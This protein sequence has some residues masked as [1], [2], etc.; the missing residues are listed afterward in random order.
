MKKVLNRF[1]A[2][3]LISIFT[4]ISIVTFFS[5]DIGLGEAVDVSAPTIQI[6]YPPS[7]AI[8]K[9]SF[10]LSGEC[11]DDVLVT[12]VYIKVENTATKKEVYNGTASITGNTWEI[13]LNNKDDVVYESTNGWQYPDGTYEVTAWAIDNS[14]KSSGKS[15]RSFDIDNTAPFFIISKPGVTVASGAEPAAYGSTFTVTGTIADLHEIS[16]MSLDVYDKNGNLLTDSASANNDQNFYETSIATAG[17]TSVEFA[18]TTRSAGLSGDVSPS[19]SIA[20]QR[21]VRLYGTVENS[22][23]TSEYK[24]TIKI[25]DSAKEY[26]NPQDNGTGEGN[27]TSYVYLNDDVYSAYLSSSKGLGLSASS[28]MSISNGTQIDNRLSSKDL[29]K[30]AIDTSDFTSKDN[31]LAFTLNPAA[32]PTYTLSGLEIYG[33][34]GIFGE[35]QLASTSNVTATVSAGL[36]NT[37]VLPN[38]VHVWVKDMTSSAPDGTIP[39]PF[40]ATEAK[41]FINKLNQIVAEKRAKMDSQSA[42]YDSNYTNTDFKKDV[43][44]ALKSQNSDDVWCVKDNTSST[45]SS[46]SLLTV[47]FEM[48]EEA[49]NFLKVNH[50][51][52]IALTGYDLDGLE[53]GQAKYYGFKATG[54][55]KLPSIFVETPANLSLVKTSAKKTANNYGLTFKGSAKNGD[56]QIDYI[57]AT[58]TVKDESDG[59]KEV[60]SISR[61][62]SIGTDIKESG[63]NGE[64]TWEFSPVDCP[65]YSSVKCEEGK[66][67]LYS[68]DFLV[69]SVDNSS[70]TVNCTVH[71]DSIKPKVTITSITPVISDYD[72]VKKSYVNGIIKVKGNIEETNL[73]SV[74]IEYIDKTTGAVKKI[75]NL[76]KIF[77]FT[78]EY[79]TRDENKGIVNNTVAN[80]AKE[81]IIKISAEDSTS[82]IDGQGNIGFTTSTIYNTESLERPENENIIVDQV[83]DKPRIKPTNFEYVESYDQIQAGKNLFGT[84]SNNTMKF[85]VED[86]DG[87][88]NNIFAYVDG[89]TKN[90]YANGYVYLGTNEALGTTAVLEGEHTVTIY[91]RDSSWI[92]DID[93]PN[94]FERKEYKIVVSAG[95]PK[96][97]FTADNNS[98]KNGAI[99]T[100]H[101]T[102]TNSSY[103]PSVVTLK[104][105]NGDTIQKEVPACS[106]SENGIVVKGTCSFT[107]EITVASLEPKETITAAYSLEDKFGQVESEKFSYVVDN[108]APVINISSVRPTVENKADS[109][110]PYVNGNI[111]A[112][113]NASDNY[114]LDK[115]EYSCYEAAEGSSI[116]V[117]SFGVVTGA[118]KCSNASLSGI[119]TDDKRFGTEIVFDTTK[120]SSD[121]TKKNLLVLLKAVDKAG[122]VACASKQYIVSQET[123]RPNIIPSNFVSL[124]N[125]AK[126]I[127][128]GVD[129]NLFGISSNNKLMG[130]IEDDDGVK[131]VICKYRK[132]SSYSLD[133]GATFNGEYESVTLISAGKSTSANL[134]QILPEAEGKYELY[135]ISKDVNY[136][137]E[138]ETPFSYVETQKYYVGVSAGAP[139]IAIFALSDDEEN[140]WNTWTRSYKDAEGENARTVSIQG[141]VSKYSLIRSI[142]RTNGSDKRDTA[143]ITDLADYA[144][145]EEANGTGSFSAKIQPYPV[146][147]NLSGEERFI[148]YTV[149]DIF[150]QSATASVQYKIDDIAPTIYTIKLQGKE[151]N[152]NTWYRGTDISIDGE[153]IDEHSG[154][155]KVHYKLIPSI[156]Q[157]SNVQSGDI[158]ATKGTANKYKFNGT[159]SGVEPGALNILELYSIDSCGNKSDVETYTIKMD[160]TAPEWTANFVSV[161]GGITANS[162][163]GTVTINGKQNISVYGQINDTQSGI[164]LLTSGNSFEY[165]IAGNSL[166]CETKFTTADVSAWDNA[167]NASYVSYSTIVDKTTITGWKTEIQKANVKDGTLVVECVDVAG[168]KFQNPSVLMFTVDNKAPEVTVRTNAIGVNGSSESIE[169]SVT[170]NYSLAGMDLYYSSSLPTNKAA[171]IYNDTSKDLTNYGWTRFSLETETDIAKIYSWD[172]SGFDF[173]SYSLAKDNSGIGTVY[174]LPVVKDKAGNSSAY[175]ITGSGN[176]ATY[177]WNAIK[178]DVD[179]NKDRPIVQVTN[180]T[181]T[182]DDLYILK[183][184]TNAQINGTISDDDA[185]ADETVKAFIGSS[186][187]IKTAVDNG[188]TWNV[189]FVDNETSV[190]NYSKN[191]STKTWTNATYGTTTLNG[192]DWTWT[193]A[194]T[195]DGPKSVLFYVEDNREGVFYTGNSESGDLL[196]PYFQFKSD[197]KENFSS[198]LAYSSDCNSPEVASVNVNS[199]KLTTDENYVSKDAIGTSLIVGGINK[200]YIQFEVLGRDANKID[201]FTLEA[202]EDG[203]EN[204][205]IKYYVGNVPAE[206]VVGWTEFGTIKVDENVETESTWITEKI[207]LNSET[208][209]N[210]W[211]T[212]DIIV[213]INVYDKSGLKGNG[214]YTFKVDNT[215]PVIENIT[216]SS[217]DEKT[218]QFDISGSANDDNT[219]RSGLASLTY[220]VPTKTDAEKTDAQ[221]ANIESIW[222]NK[223]AVMKDWLFSF[224]GG[225]TT[226]DCPAFET[227][228]TTG[229]GVVDGNNIWTI[230]VYIKAVDVLGNVAIAKHS[231]KYNP[232]GDKPKTEFTYP[233]DTQYKENEGY[234]TLG[235]TIRVTGTVTIPN[236]DSRAVSDGVYI[237]LATEEDAKNGRWDSTKIPYKAGSTERYTVVKADTINANNSEK[238]N[239][240]SYASNASGFSSESDR[241]AWWGISAQ[242]TSS[243]WVMAINSN[244]EL[245]PTIEGQT[246]N[247]AIRACSVN[248]AGKVG[249]WSNTYYIHVDN[250]APVMDIKLRQYDIPFNSANANS[251]NNSTKKAE[252]DYVPGMYLKGNWYIYLEITDE[253]GIDSSNSGVHVEDGKTFYKAT[254]NVGGK[255]CYKVW[256]PVTGN[257]GDLLKYTITACDTD[258]GNTHEVKNT[259]QLYIDNT[260]PEFGTI[261]TTT[262]GSNSFAPESG[263]SKYK[264]KDSNKSFNISS[265]VTEK[266]S[267]FERTVFYLIRKKNASSYTI[268]NDS[269]QSIFDSFS[270]DSSTLFPKE[271]KV[272][273]SGLTEIRIPQDGVEYSLWGKTETGSQTEG[274]TTYKN[275]FYVNVSNNTHIHKGGLIYIGNLLRRIENITSSYVEFDEATDGTE[276]SAV[277]V[278]AQIVDNMTTEGGSPAISD[279]GFTFTDTDDGDGMP[280]KID[281]TSS[282]VKWN[283]DIRSA[284]L[285]DGPI[286]LVIL[287]FD[288]AGNVSCKEI[289][290]CIANNAP[291]IAKVF[292][293]TDIDGDAKYSANE[294]VEY[295]WSVDNRGDIITSAYTDAMT[296]KTKDYVG[297]TK[298]EGNG[299]AFIIKN[300][301][302]VVPEIVGGNLKTDNDG[303]ITGSMGLVYS[304]N[305]TEI[306]PVTGTIKNEASA[307]TWQLPTEAMLTDANNKFYA[308]TLS[309][310]DISGTDNLATATES[311]VDGENKKMSFTFWDETEEGIKGQSTQNAVLF[312]ED[313]T[314]DLI[315]GKSPKATIHPFH[316]NSRTDNSIQK[317]TKGNLLGHIELESDLKSTDEWNSPFTSTNGVMDKDP[318]VSGKIILTGFAYDETR[319]SKLEIKE[320]T[321]NFRLTNCYSEYKALVVGGDVVW[322]QTE[323]TTEGWKLVVNNK[324]NPDQQGHLIEWTLELDTEKVINVAATD[325]KWTVVATDASIKNTKNTSTPGTNVTTRQTVYATKTQYAL[326]KFYETAVASSNGSVIFD[327]D[328]E[329][330]YEEGIADSTYKDVYAYNYGT[331]GY[332]QMDVVP[333]ITEVATPSLSSVNKRVPSVY[334]RTA[335]GHYSVRADEIVTLKGFNLGATTTVNINSFNKSKEYEHTVNGITSLNNINNNDAVGS[336]TSDVVIEKNGNYSLY[337]NYYNRQPNDNNNDLLTDDIFFDVWQFKSDAAKPIDGKVEQPHMKINPVTGNIGFA[338]VSGPLQFSMPRGVR[339]INNNG[340]VD[341]SYTPTSYDYWIASYDFFTSVGFTFDDN[342]RSWGVAA[343]GDIN[344]TQADHFNLMSSQWGKGGTNKDG[345]YV[346]GNIISLEAIAQNAN[347]VNSFNKQRIKSS[348]L[349][350]TVTGYNTNLYIAYYD[351]MN[352]EIRFRAG[353]T[354]SATQ[355]STNFGNF[356]N[357]VSGRGVPNYKNT[358]VQI[359]SDSTMNAKPGEYLSIAAT[360]NAVVMVWFDETNRCLQYA[361]TTNPMVNTPNGSSTNWTIVA[362]PIFAGEDY[363]SAGEYCQVVAD[364]NGGIHIA[365]YDSVNCDLIYAYAPSYN[366]VFTSCVVDS[367]GVVGANL[368]IDV[369]LD[370]ANKPLVNIAYYATSAVRPKYAKNVYPGIVSDGVIDDKY[371]GAWECSTIPISTSNPPTMQSNQYNMINVGVWKN[372]D[373]GVIKNS[374]TI[375]YKAD[376]TNSG[377]TASDH[378]S[379]T[380]YGAWSWGWA[381]GN[382]TSNAVLGYAIKVN[383]TTDA[384]ETAQL[385]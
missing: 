82:S 73:K 325:L 314:V 254:W 80:N 100:V 339:Y 57:Q 302:A 383:S 180:L 60:G 146:T 11:K 106:V 49:G 139:T 117:D 202:K 176:T 224:N 372:K 223:T 342:G 322:N 83:S 242:S 276:T 343:G 141:T 112:V 125:G 124:I 381:M 143:S 88:V 329:K 158:V 70:Q 17:G 306:A 144:L 191:G 55:G 258:Q 272:A 356:V 214:S 92:S 48:R 115:I 9:D 340:K 6:N 184:G 16:K 200:R 87:I 63:T 160:E 69:H 338:F 290:T 364:K 7:R 129:G 297:G 248:S 245:N 13:T 274:S 296:L 259:Y 39:N 132:A 109:T 307:A 273:T 278:Y 175:K 251:L 225:G 44:A 337:Q 145:I 54:T 215:A 283:A 188:S 196:K 255:N 81:I 305:A 256:I 41:E 193:P 116:S 298:S 148:E 362:N 308:W 155:S 249:A 229:F 66:S 151:H 127:K 187:A 287:A 327:F 275:R 216:P 2:K 12:N 150:G 361:Y 385:K 101:G 56:T 207:D 212:G 35:N 170:E 303:N 37:S 94:N 136:K 103:S 68:V 64:W 371:T 113:F 379:G 253:S 34:D 107:D 40:S 332:Y 220:C 277:F 328:I 350:S 230:P 45:A 26:K 32:N 86:D 174:I 42:V 244:G 186:K 261:T 213:T 288:K 142:L 33:T 21:Y 133:G 96:I 250:S 311:S 131:E 226:Y 263:M 183:Y 360:N 219:G 378:T 236:I 156:S 234:V 271:T 173:N 333:Y 198:A 121:A 346:G 111:I 334:A 380:G 118:T 384:I 353:T 313:F 52:I 8:I 76:G 120:I 347:G 323:N 152:N 289:D 206:A 166:I 240:A 172:Y 123:D 74:K 265:P 344:E 354:G 321:N 190:F 102:L 375:I 335:L 46:G 189:T 1:G 349:A 382:G 264:I 114:D 238:I 167:K 22:T 218:G 71:V 28:L 252:K 316:W 304:N 352:D 211:I 140:I 239:I 351:S 85:A 24:C 201:G 128:N 345:S 179:M 341:T 317:D 164:G 368:T 280:E 38:T 291:R 59:N 10:V 27:T 138:A 50:Y 163:T 286:T 20:Y 270:L 281:V 43:I 62:L 369:A 168:S 84:T 318:K 266:G 293:G 36:N 221:L 23:T 130:S 18:N 357:D 162:A 355:G 210:K 315:D 77:S 58:V 161:D 153:Y 209:A 91:A 122:T 47:P 181:K 182:T 171:E 247:I 312:V 241:S 228:A 185:T 373:T 231:I 336:F 320:T 194:N 237:Q 358:N 75:V 299:R 367:Y 61:K 217:S 192:T 169:G 178:F 53:F 331:T 98:Y 319:L 235:S 199:Y 90:R 370:N 78:D 119:I 14:G 208:L 108:Q 4:L 93:T 89:E 99:I 205:K 282:G 15:S 203:Q 348:S 222:Q 377:E 300:G 177:S 5:C 72:D 105:S 227:Y 154:I 309:N 67:Y 324:R 197:A 97:T 267:G 29:L 359:V 204:S 51:Y 159:I 25:T 110:I 310:K 269:V 294:F 157:L 165:K 262:S 292:L 104:K 376:G 301:L 330:V 257:E 243:S 260:A 195:D 246:N 365:A 147:A 374:N 135:F 65:N 126:E 137:N 134:S 284:N 295:N 366:G 30:K 19:D 285:S 31:R 326:G 3:V 233:T 279:Y 268:Q 149:T 95:A 232:D 363:D 79:D